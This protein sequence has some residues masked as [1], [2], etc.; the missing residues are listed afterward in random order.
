M[1]TACATLTIFILAGCVSP[2][3]REA[4][5]VNSAHPC[6]ENELRLRDAMQCLEERGYSE[7]YKSKGR[8]SFSSCGL[9]WGFPFMSSCSGI[10][11]YHEDGVISS[12]DIKGFLD[13]I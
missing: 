4:R 2:A 6:L 12:Y 10:T 13:G 7:W 8:N 5:L 9:Y 11:I 1:K 3:T